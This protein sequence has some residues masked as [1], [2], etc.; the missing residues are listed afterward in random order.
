[1]GLTSVMERMMRT[2]VDEMNAN[3]IRLAIKKHARELD[4]LILMLKK[5]EK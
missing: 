2:K 5:Y 1:M 3:R 4:R